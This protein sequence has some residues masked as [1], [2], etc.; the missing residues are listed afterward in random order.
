MQY[1][2]KRQHK[3]RTQTQNL[4]FYSKRRKFSTMR[5]LL[6]KLSFNKSEKKSRKKRRRV[7][8][9]KNPIIIESE[10]DNEP[11][12]KADLW[13][14]SEE[15]ASIRA[16]NG[17]IVA[18][19]L[20]APWRKAEL[21]VEF[22]DCFRGLERK[23][24]QNH[25]RAHGNRQECLAAILSI[26]EVQELQNYSDPE[27]IAAVYGSLSQGPVKHAIR[28]ARRDEEFVKRYTSK[29]NLA[30][31]RTRTGARPR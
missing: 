14:G 11:C 22:G 25:N 28:M 26:Q 7:S 6:R 1:F 30:L 8:F 16:S 24:P 15:Q 23:I 12:N 5:K 20:A 13:Y 3:T 2:Q 17:R 18:S 27:P 19:L 31:S 4:S 29:E 21:E 10:G 9:D